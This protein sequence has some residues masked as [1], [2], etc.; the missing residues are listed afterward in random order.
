MFSQLNLK[1][2]KEIVN[3]SYQ[4]KFANFLIS[5][6]EYFGEQFDT[7]EWEKD[8]FETILLKNGMIAIWKLNN[9]IIF[10]ECNRIGNIDFDGLGKDLFC[11]TRNGIS[12]TFDN[13][14]KSKDVVVIYNNDSH[15][16]DFNIDRFADLMTESWISLKAGILGTRYNDIILVESEKDKIELEK[17]MNLSNS[18]KPILLKSNTKNIFEDSKECEHIQLSDIKNSDKLQYIAN[19]IS[20]IEREFYNMYG[21][22]TQGADKMA[23]QSVAEINNGAWSSWVEVLSRLHERIKGFEKCNE[24]FGTDFSCALSETWENEYNRLFKIVE[25]GDENKIVKKGDENKI[26]ENDGENKIVESGDEE[27]VFE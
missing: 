12:K 25:N 18:G 14:K 2:Q 6:F 27:N 20:F 21:M 16:Y 1:T 13:F 10:S 22:T 3:F 24:I 15:T 8:I 5:M 9:K 26:V 17:A 4:D 7:G 11:V 19:T 23:Q